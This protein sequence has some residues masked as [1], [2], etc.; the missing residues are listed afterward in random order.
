[1][2]VRGGIAPAGGSG[3]LAVP[4]PAA[5]GIKGLVPMCGCDGRTAPG[6][7]AAPADIPGARGGIAV[8][9]GAGNLGG[10]AW[11]RGRAR[12]GSKGTTGIRFLA[13]G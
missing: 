11:P 4:A 6:G 8:V 3:A 5:P 9:A 1:M 13:S 2:V 10:R 12:A 7:S